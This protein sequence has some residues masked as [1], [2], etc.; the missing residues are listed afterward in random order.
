ME[1]FISVKFRIE[2][3]ILF[4]ICNTG[5]IAILNSGPVGYQET[6]RGAAGRAQQV[7]HHWK[8]WDR[9]GKHQQGDHGADKAH[10]EAGLQQ[11]MVSGLIN[12]LCQFFFYGLNE[13]GL[14][15]RLLRLKFVVV[16]VKVQQLKE[17]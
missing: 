1:I 4:G 6:A 3:R 16:A 12:R 13:S 11:H 8:G 10:R 2:I 9:A 7:S 5:T 14:N 17:V 15:N